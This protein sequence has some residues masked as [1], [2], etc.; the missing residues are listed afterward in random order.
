MNRKPLPKLLILVL[1][2]TAAMIALA[3]QRPTD[4]Q[5]K[6]GLPERL[7]GPIDANFYVDVL[8]RP[9]DP[10]MLSALRA[11]FTSKASVPEREIV[12]AILLRLGD[13]SD[14]YFNYLAGP[15]KVAVEDRTPQ[16]RRNDAKIDDPIE[17]TPEFTKWCEENHKDPKEILD[18]QYHVYPR[19]LQQLA[20]AQD[21]RSREIFRKGVES[22]LLFVL[23]ASVEG[24][25]RLHDT[26]ALPSI[27]RAVSRDRE[28]LALPVAMQLPWFRD[29]EAERWID[30]LVPDP[31]LKKIPDMERERVE[32]EARWDELHK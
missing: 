9:S 2:G 3:E 21:A 28:N 13:R 17:Y 8:S 31:V 25:G 7:R 27:I 5:F 16:A 15:A 20:L 32:I 4:Q 11:A 1:L 18:L 14:I 26:A 22:P 6:A 12:A 10:A 19:V 29:P 24:L 23:L 30:L